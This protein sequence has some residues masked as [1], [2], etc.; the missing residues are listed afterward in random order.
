MGKIFKI[1]LGLTLICFSTKSQ[2]LLPYGFPSPKSTGYYE[3][4]WMQT[5]SGIINSVRDTT[6]RPRFAG[7]QFLWQHNGVDSNIWYYDG[8]KFF[9]YL[10]TANDIVNALGYTPQPQISLTTIGSSGAATFIN[11]TLNV[12][13]YAGGGG[14][15]NIVSI[16]SLTSANLFIVTG[17]T[18]SDFNINSTG[19]TITLNIPTG[20]VAT[21]GLISTT[22]WATFNAK[23]PQLNGTGFVKAS[24]TT[25]SYDNSTYYLA[26]NPSSFISRTGISAN[27]PILY[28]NG[29]GVFSADT[30]TGLTH[31]ATQAYVLANQASGTITGAG[32]LTPLFT[33]SVSSNT[34][35]FALS[36]ASA[37]TALT[38]STSGT[39]APAYGK[40][41]NATLSN[42]SITFSSTDLTGSGTIAL[43]ATL[44]S[45]INNNA[46]TYAKFQTITANSLFGNPTGSLAN[47][48]AITIGYGLKVV[49]GALVADTSI[50]KDTIYAVNGT[51]FLGTTHDS[52]GLGG[53]LYQA[54]TIS[55]N[56]GLTLS[57]LASFNLTNGTIDNKT[58]TS[59]DSLVLR[60][61]AGRL[62]S[63]PALT[64][65]TIGSSGAATYTPSTGVLNIPS[66]TGGGGSTVLQTNYIGV[67]VSNV[68][69]QTGS[70][71]FDGTIQTVGAMQ[72]AYKTSGS[73][74]MI[75]DS[76]SLPATYSNNTTIFGYKAW[77]SSATAAPRNTGF[78][79]NIFLAIGTAADLSAF[80][81]GAAAAVTFATDGCFFGS[82]SGN[83]VTTSSYNTFYGFAS[84]Q[85]ITTG[86]KN[87]VFAPKVGAN[88]ILAATSSR[89]IYIGLDSIATTPALVYNSIYIGDSYQAVRSNLAVLGT[90]TQVLSFGNGGMST[91]AYTALGTT[92]TAGDFYFNT[93]STSTG[94]GYVAYTGS[95]WINLG[96]SSSG[97]SSV[98]TRQ[99]ITSGSSGTV[100]GGKYLVQFN[101]SSVAASYSLTTPASPADQDVVDI[102][103]GTTIAAP[104]TEITSFTLVANSGQTF[105]FY[106]S[107]TAVPFYSGTHIKIRWNAT[108]A[109]WDRTE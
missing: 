38:N 53:A 58:A 92:A 109:F 49:A 10:R 44:T 89:N 33:T 45:N 88:P 77:N 36:T 28:N 37:N 34:I 107:L 61:A 2:T 9:R 21:R 104:G 73:T 83:A 97:G 93:D 62:W 103:T 106:S 105:N 100:T 4:G 70:F 42:S 82:G 56:F 84:G 85:G 71:R 19:S 12:P 81:H 96:G 22:D 43:G 17:S 20:S 65:T 15:G 24:G 87:L 72:S 102:Q 16:N 51:T 86:A 66:Y 75:T 32:N 31:L 94:S 7:T 95:K 29:T 68:L 90:Q 8:S 59:T 52:I 30:T 25:I 48:Q 39:A 26:S 13:N 101:F 3:I 55:G 35:V 91:T 69:G 41:N 46:V 98:L 60:D 54:T 63:T 108:G 6:V 64:L 47:G 99:N 40:I 57:G 74:Y 50:L 11:N 67:G 14:G 1:L 27:A 18:G 78:G 79:D 76:T 23:Q 5:D 80:G